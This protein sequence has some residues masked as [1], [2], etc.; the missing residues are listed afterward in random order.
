ML[1]PSLSPVAHR[2]DTPALSERVRSCFRRFRFR[3]LPKRL[4]KGDLP[5]R[6]TKPL[7]L[8]ISSPGG[9]WVQLRRMR[10]AWENCTVIYASALDGY[11]NEVASDALEGRTWATYYVITDANRWQRLRLF[12]QISDIAILVLRYRPDVIVS[13]GAAAG[14]FALRIG[15]LVGSRTIWVD[16]IANAETVSMAG[17]LVAPHADLWLTQWEDLA[18]D[19]GPYFLGAVI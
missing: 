3:L 13:T 15:K 9:H 11:A 8:A 4:L 14:Y 10:A 5:E 16:S 2:I 17:Q 1:F 7:V 6:S 18:R 12:K 19:E